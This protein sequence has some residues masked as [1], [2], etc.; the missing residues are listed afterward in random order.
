MTSYSTP[1]DKKVD[2][3]IGARLREIR[4]TRGFSQEKVADA[5]D[6]TYQQ[7]QKYEFGTNRISGSRMVALCKLL[8]TT[9][10]QLTGTDDVPTRVTTHRLSS[11]A[12]RV[13]LRYDKLDTSQ[14]RVVSLL[15]EQ[16]LQENGNA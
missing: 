7:I 12:V 4:I 9:P 8:E 2:Q 3:Q 5:L 14:K 6:L 10:N 16:F 11:H 13:G 1:E 15:I